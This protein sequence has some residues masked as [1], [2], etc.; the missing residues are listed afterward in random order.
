MIPLSRVEIPAVT[1]AQMREVDR[2]MIEVYGIDLI[3]MMEHAGRSLHEV[4][5]DKYLHGNPLG[6]RVVVLAGKGGNGG[7]ALVA[8]RWLANAGADIAAVIAADRDQFAPVPAHLLR[9]LERIGVPVLT[10]DAPALSGRTDLI[11][12]GVARVWRP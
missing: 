8:G 12:D 3:Q 9:I 10:L 6:K 2:L 4:A 7:G 5:R 1:A 11:L